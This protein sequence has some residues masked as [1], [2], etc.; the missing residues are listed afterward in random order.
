MRTRK[1]FIAGF[2]TTGALMAATVCMFAVVSAIVAFEGWPS[3]QVGRPATTLDDGGVLG[4]SAEGGG[5]V[6]DSGGEAVT[7][8]AH[9]HR[10]LGKR[11]ARGSGELG[12]VVGDE[13]SEVKGIS[14]L[15]EVERGASDSSTIPPAARGSAQDGLG[16]GT[17]DDGDPPPSGPSGSSGSPPSQ[18]PAGDGTGSSGDGGLGGTVEEVTSSLGATVGQ[19]GAALGATVGQ[20]GAALGT[21]VGTTTGQLGATVGQVSPALGQTVVQ[22]GQV[23]G[24]ALAGTTGTVGQVVSGTGGV[25]G[26]LLGGLGSRRSTSSR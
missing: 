14:G 10:A 3:V 7:R 2:G 26:G 4:T 12:G 6:T 25:V 16:G 8:T 23:V 21:T 9:S 13:Q 20:T 1:A 18:P 11:P 15:G 5:A 19:T 22:T 17:S 24:T